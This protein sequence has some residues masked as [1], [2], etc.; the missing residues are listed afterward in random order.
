MAE[1]LGLGITHY[2]PLCW[3]DEHMAFP[4][5][6]T[7]EDPGIPEPE[8]DPAAWPAAMRVELGADDGLSSA[9]RHRA[10][11]V[12]GFAQV[13]AALDE[14][15]PDVVVIWGDDQYEN[16]H[17]DVIPAFCVLALDDET[18]TPWIDPIMPAPN[19]WGE[20]AEAPWTIAGAP[21]VGRH[22]A[23]GLLDRDID[24]AYAYQ[25]LHREKYPHAILNS[26]L[27]L[28]YQR[29][30]FPYRV[31]PFTVNCYG[32]LI[33]T[34]RGGLARF[35]EA[36]AIEATDPRSPSPR[37]CMQLGRAAV[38]VLRDSPWRVAMVASSSWSHAFLHDKAWRLY[39]DVDADRA[40]YEALQH[41]KYE[42][43][44][45]VTL[46]DVEAAG[47]QE[48]LNWFCLAG[49]MQALDRIPSWS[50]FVETHIFNSNKC[51][52]IYPG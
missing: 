21:D 28:D 51:F 8:R 45:A 25:R 44:E 17:E 18:V 19:V 24:V 32:R 46:D 4:L 12:D 52:A 16:F 11:L 14:F 22:L 1:I 36:G 37:R 10:A 50:T 39:P 29:V 20:P 23:D 2:P 6:W 43:W 31:V 3:P 38:D 13:R 34:R 7:L 15:R 41:G 40:L 48:M 9:A 30:G 33:V 42:T 47:Q 35:P 26:L 5:R 27:F 49:A